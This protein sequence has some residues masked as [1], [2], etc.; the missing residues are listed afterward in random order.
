MRI[1]LQAKFWIR[2]GGHGSASRLDDHLRPVQHTSRFFSGDY[3]LKNKCH[4]LM[5][6]FDTTLQACFLL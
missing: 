1:K 3:E 4:R 6:T 5:V 2:I